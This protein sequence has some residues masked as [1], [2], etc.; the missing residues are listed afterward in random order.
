M[1]TYGP[2]KRLVCVGG[3][4]AG[5]MEDR[6]QHLYASPEGTIIN[7]LTFDFYNCPIFKFDSISINRV[8]EN[9]HMNI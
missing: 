6:S 3:F 7:Q 8:E 5:V 4:E 2:G 1:I 9:D